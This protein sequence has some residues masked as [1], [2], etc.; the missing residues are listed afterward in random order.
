MP[1]FWPDPKCSMN[2]KQLRRERRIRNKAGRERHRARIERN[3]LIWCNELGDPV[4]VMDD[5]CEA[6]VK[7]LLLHWLT[8]RAL[9]TDI[10]TQVTAK[11]QERVE[12]IILKTLVDRLPL[13]YDFPQGLEANLWRMLSRV[14]TLGATVNAPPIQPTIKVW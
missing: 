11:M 2:R 4:T 12:D 14:S 5:P 9:L 7:A 3:R 10:T 8:P 1:C 6:H 13:E